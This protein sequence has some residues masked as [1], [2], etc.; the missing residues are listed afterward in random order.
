MIKTESWVQIKESNKFD[1]FFWHESPVEG[2]KMKHDFEGPLWP[3]RMS[4]ILH[5]LGFIQNVEDSV[6]IWCVRNFQTV[7]TLN[8][9]VQPSRE[10]SN[11]ILKWL[12]FKNDW[13]LKS[14]KVLKQFFLADWRSKTKIGSTF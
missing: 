11:K 5:S 4:F 9:S 3:K 13:K 14:I 1:T 7:R 12:S 6:L 2:M 10:S 8:I